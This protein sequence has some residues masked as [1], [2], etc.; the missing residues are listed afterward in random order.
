MINGVKSF[1]PVDNGDFVWLAGLVMTALLSGCATAR[2]AE[3]EVIE[4]QETPFRKIVL[5]VDLADPIDTESLAK[6]LI[7]RLESYDLKVVAAESAGT[8]SGY[9]GAGTGLLKIDEVD[10]RLET[11][12]YHRTYGRTSLTQMRGRKSADVPVITL[13]AAFADAASGKTV[14]RAEYVAQGPWYADSA[15]VV[16]SLASTLVDQLANAGIIASR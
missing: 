8:G 11:V 6:R 4:A 10:R 5:K 1:G 3:T 7:G 16:A 14:Y 13:R 15:S 2:L 12:N 9:T